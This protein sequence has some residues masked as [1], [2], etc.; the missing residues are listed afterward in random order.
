MRVQGAFQKTDCEEMFLGCVFFFFFLVAKDGFLLRKISVRK[1][2][3]P[4]L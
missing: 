3:N 2:N 4:L 1:K